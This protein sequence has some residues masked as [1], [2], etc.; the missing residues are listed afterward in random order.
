[1]EVVFQNNVLG[2]TVKSFDA[3]FLRVTVKINPA[4]QKLEISSYKIMMAFATFLDFDN[5]FCWI[6]FQI[7]MIPTLW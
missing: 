7:Q 4:V 3:C 1:M 5:L 2:F 6:F